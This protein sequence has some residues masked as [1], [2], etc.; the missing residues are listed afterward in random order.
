MS[1]EVDI[2]NLALAHIGD[3]AQV[4]AIRPADGTVQA[5]H[6]ARFY[7]M[8]RDLLLEM[9]PWTFAT[10]RAQVAEVEN[11][12]PDDWQYAY[13]LPSTCIRPLSA[14]LSGV[15]ERSFGNSD[16]DAG[17]FPYIVEASADGTPVLYTNVETAVLRYIDRVTDTTRFSPGFVAA[18]GRLLASYLSGPILKGDSGAKQAIEQMKL[19][20]VEYARATAANANVGK[21]S[22]YQTYRPVWLAGRGAPSL[23]DAQVVYPGT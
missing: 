6:C 7:P 14:L 23:P 18:F 20:T 9:H 12:S 17:S 10:K 8:A 11:P 5:D 4:V 1:S 22:T 21:R 13:A 2:C 15:P 3:E 19:F 16:T